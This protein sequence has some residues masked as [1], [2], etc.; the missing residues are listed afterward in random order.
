MLKRFGVLGLVLSAGLLLQPVAALAADRGHGSNNV[1]RR[2]DVRVEQY[3]E[4]ARRD[5]HYRFERR[6]ERVIINT[7]PA[8]YYPP[9]AGCA[10]RH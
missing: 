9:A 5:D 2:N 1:E 7:A 10:Y 4:P 8:Y 3:R 6:P